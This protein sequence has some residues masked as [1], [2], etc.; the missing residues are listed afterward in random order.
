LDHEAD[1]LIPTALWKRKKTGI[2]WQ[3][4][5]NLSI[6]I[7]QGFNLV[8]PI[9][10]VNLIAAVGNRGI[11]YRPL[12]LKRIETARGE[13][14]QK[15]SPQELGQAEFSEQ[16]VALV[17]RGLWETVNTIGGT[18]Y[19]SRLKDV[20]MSGKTGT[21]QVV[22]RK[23]DEAAEDEEEVADHLKDHAWFVAFA[24]S[25]NPQIAVAVIVEHGEHGSS[26]AAPIASQM[27]KT[28]LDG[29]T[30]GRALAKTE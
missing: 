9:Q 8:T 21:A 7:G 23:D 4:G 1:G 17:R 19:R 5:E 12:I 15:A 28:Y 10:M 14:V 6:A 20:P 29:R 22:G 13:V 30:G 24:P 2:P 26:A 25:E 3:P 16:T 11:R 27:I 18:A